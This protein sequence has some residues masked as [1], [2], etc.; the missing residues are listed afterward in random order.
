MMH[1]M[2]PDITSSEPIGLIAGQGE[3]PRLVAEGIHQAGRRVAAVGLAGQCEP[4]LESQCDEFGQ[5]GIASLGKWIRL[6]KRWGVRE[7]VMVGRVSH[8]RKYAPLQW[9]RYRPDWRALRLWYRCL[10]EDRRTATMLTAL[11]EDLGKSGVQLIDSRTYIQDHLAARGQMGH[12]PLTESMQRDVTF[13][14]PLL[15]QALELGIGQSM[16][17]RGCDVVAVEAAEGTDRMV[18]RTAQLVQGRAWALLKSSSQSH[19]MRADVATIGTETVERVAAAGGKA[20]VVG[21]RRVI[22]VDKP[23]VVSAA[24]RLGIALVGME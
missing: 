15:T 3:L 5:A 20:I 22:L 24:D 21:V 14:W 7:A 23:K 1:G 8:E 2:P 9:L 6:L 19:D 16:A 11:A 18:E 10:R 17:I 4:D 13:G 12:V